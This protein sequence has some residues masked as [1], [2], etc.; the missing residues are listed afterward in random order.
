MP[1]GIDATFA[2]IEAQS[3]EKLLVTLYRLVYTVGSQ[4]VGEA[5]DYAADP[6]PRS[7]PPRSFGGKPALPPTDQA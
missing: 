7:A 4:R 1:D 2:R 6:E 5:L 3:H